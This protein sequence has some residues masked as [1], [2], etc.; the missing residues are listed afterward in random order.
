ME[1]VNLAMPSRSRSLLRAFTGSANAAAC[2][3]RTGSLLAGVVLALSAQ[4]AD[5]QEQ[6]AALLRYTGVENPAPADVA[7]MADLWTKVQLPGLRTNERRAAFRDMYLL[8]AKLQGRD[9][10]ARP[11][12]LDGLAQFTTTVFE[13]AAVWI[14]ACRSRAVSRTALTFTLKVVD[15]ERHRCCSFQVWGST[16]ETCMA[17][18]LTGRV[19]PIP[20]I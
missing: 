7:R 5:I 14:S 13:A 10:T 6:M 18:L 16:A 9:L 8:S 12:A 1:R 3:A 15:T 4:A 2:L 11:Q 19:T 20:C 17:R